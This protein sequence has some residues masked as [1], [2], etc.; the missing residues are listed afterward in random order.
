MRKATVPSIYLSNAQVV[1]MRFPRDSLERP[2]HR[3][4][5]IVSGRPTRRSTAKIVV[6]FDKQGNVTPGDVLERTH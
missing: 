3:P 4:S 2:S 1:A 6:R 5:S